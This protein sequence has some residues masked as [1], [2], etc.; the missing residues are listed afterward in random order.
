MFTDKPSDT[1]NDT[2]TDP[3]FRISNYGG[4]IFNDSNDQ[5]G[6]ENA[7]SG[8]YEW[9]GRDCWGTTYDI[10][11]GRFLIVMSYC[12]FLKHTSN[13]KDTDLKNNKAI[14]CALITL[15]HEFIHAKLSI[16]RHLQEVD[17]KINGTSSS[18]TYIP[19]DNTTCWHDGPFMKSLAHTV[20]MWNQQKGV[21]KVKKSPS[22][23]PEA[24]FSEGKLY[25]SPKK[26]FFK[27]S[28]GQNTK[29]LKV[30]FYFN[31]IYFINY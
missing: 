15:I 26:E 17:Y 31:C 2:N 24:F 6:F 10:G 23:G 27:L 3:N 18:Q 28:G 5:G 4:L 11:E 9:N 1:G 22:D 13:T 19:K 7:E 14:D 25:D 20:Y 8:K 16:N 30:Y 21:R 12:H 29:H